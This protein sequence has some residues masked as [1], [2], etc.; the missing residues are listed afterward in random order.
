M[1]RDADVTEGAA[2]ARSTSDLPA[3]VGPVK[4][5][6]PLAAPAPEVARLAVLPDRRH[7][8]GD[9]PPAPDLPRV[10]GAPAAHV[11][12]AV[13]LKPA[14]RILRVDPPL[15]RHVASDCE[16][17]TLKKFRRALRR[18]LASFACVNQLA[19]NSSRQSVMYLPPNTPR[20]SICFGVSSGVK[21]GAKFFPAGSV[22]K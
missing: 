13:P 19:G 18:P 9:R 20:R 1:R 3:V 15:R 4:D 16:A 14:A 17:L 12:P 10:V 8:P 2:R 6:L 22:R 7:V 5:R 21:P 11:V